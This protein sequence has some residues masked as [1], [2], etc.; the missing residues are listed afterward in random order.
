MVRF[1][2]AVMASDRCGERNPYRFVEAG[3]DID[4]RQHEKRKLPNQALEPIASAPVQLFVVHLNHMQ[5]II[6]T[7]RLFLRDL[8]QNDV[9]CLIELFGDPLQPIVQVS[10]YAADN[11]FC[12][13][14]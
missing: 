12:K 11:C 8:T 6:E 13:P 10:R 7:N 3:A 5:K 1:C 9:D 2:T 14:S 4:E